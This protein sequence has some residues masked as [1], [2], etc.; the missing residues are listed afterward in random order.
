METT[1]QRQIEEKK[2]EF[3]RVV[4]AM[5]K[6]PT[7]L[8]KIKEKNGTDLVVYRDGKIQYIKPEDIKL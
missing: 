3:E 6:I 8:K 5:R 7:R 2:V 1:K 4:E